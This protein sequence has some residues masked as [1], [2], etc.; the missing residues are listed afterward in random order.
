[1]RIHGRFVMLLMVAGLITVRTTASQPAAAAEPLAIARILAARYPAQPI[2]SYIPA[3]SWSGSMRL[4]T[5]TKEPQWREKAVKEMQ[6]FVGGST[7]AIAEPYRL[8]SLAGGLALADAATM[9]ND[10][11]A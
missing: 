2:M 8:T 11:A 9:A 7:P 10:S 4:T 3:L 5:L 6:A 1:M